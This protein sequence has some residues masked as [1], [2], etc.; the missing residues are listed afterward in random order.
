MFYLNAVFSAVIDTSNL[1]IYT[2][3]ADSILH[4]CHQLPHLKFY[5]ELYI[6]F[7]NRAETKIHICNQ[8][9]I[10]FFTKKKYEKKNT[11]L[12]PNL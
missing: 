8:S 7:M 9:S 10:P 12:V 5:H 6:E 11:N 1:N 2:F 4:Y 3:F